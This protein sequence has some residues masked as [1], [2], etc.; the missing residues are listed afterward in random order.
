[1]KNRK[2]RI[3]TAALALVMASVALAGCS[4]DT[5][6]SSIDMEN[7]SLDVMTMSFNTT[8]APA[9]SPVVQELEDYLGTKLNFKW[10]PSTGYDEKVTTTMGSGK[11]PHIML[12][13]TVSASVINAS[14]ND[15]FWDITD[16]ITDENKYPNL[17]KSDPNI[18][19]NISIDSRV[20]GIYRSRELGRSGI[21]I[22]KDWLDNLGLDMPKTIDDLY[23]VLKA[24]KEDD[25][26]RN[27]KDDTYGMIVTKYLE[28]PLDN[29][30][31]WMGAPNEWGVDETTG[32]LVP[33][34]KTPEF[35][36]ALDFMRKCYAEGLINQD[37]ATYDSERWNE[38]FL[39]GNAGVII[40]L[41]S[42]ARRISENMQNTNPNAVV[43]VI[44]YVKK[45]EN[46]EPKTRP[47]TGYSGYYVFPKQSVKTEQDLDFILSVMDKANEQE[48]QNLMNYGI[49]ERNY[50]VKDGYAEKKDDSSLI[51]E[52][53][54]LN[55]FSTQIIAPALKTKYTSSLAEKVDK[56]YEENRKYVVS[57]IAEPYISDTYSTKGPQLDA[58]IEEAKVKYIVGQIDE[59]EWQKQVERWE[60]NGGADVIKE[61]N[62]AYKNDSY[63]KK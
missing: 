43:D 22:R 23:N 57:N 61:I 45:D 39:Q 58:I 13:D 3:V 28:G 41:A 50:T 40:D 5:Q 11:Y 18:N 17:A 34:F 35:K 4:D 52:Y 49:E 9:D 15:I 30:A 12:I 38:Q 32:E 6:T 47:T 20:Y 10:V 21:T 51:V 48:A 8:S 37:M 7:P 56:V 46:T 63:L 27:G 44:G 62:E 59:N 1:M 55:Q 31:I 36:N 33:D 25:P 42:R 19:H 26:D 53:N 16:K 2:K 54:D 29:L 14:R 60:A 24:F